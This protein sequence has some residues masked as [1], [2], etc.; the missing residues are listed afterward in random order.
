MAVVLGPSAAHRVAS[1]LM[2]LGLVGVVGFVL[3]GVVPPSSV[4]AVVGFGAVALVA[5]QADP[6]LATMLLIRASYVFLALL[7]AAVWFRPFA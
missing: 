4:A 3:A 6:E 1:A 5:R 7:V 2:V